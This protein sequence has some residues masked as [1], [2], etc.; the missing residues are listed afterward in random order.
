[1][2]SIQHIVASVF[3]ATS[4]KTSTK[5]VQYKIFLTIPLK[6]M[7]MLGEFDGMSKH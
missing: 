2:L 3:Y 6:L 7:E 5:S 4:Q 1:M